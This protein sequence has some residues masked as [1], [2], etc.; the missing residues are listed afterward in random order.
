VV[1]EAAA[2]GIPIVATKV[3]GIPDFIQSGKNGILAEQADS[4]G[5]AQSIIDVVSDQAL[6]ARITSNARNLVEADYSWKSVV[7]RFDLL[8]RELLP[9][10]TGREKSFLMKL[11]QAVKKA[12]LLRTLPIRC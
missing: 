3:G 1:L 6:R 4:P 5:L 2:C 9:N 11:K 8:I 10:K 12:P 7:D